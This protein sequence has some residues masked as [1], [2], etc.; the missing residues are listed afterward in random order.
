MEPNLLELSSWR[1]ALLLL[2]PLLY[3]GAA[4]A[5]TAFRARPDTGWRIARWSAA[6][7]MA[8]ALLSLIALLVSGA[9][10]V[11][12]PALLSLGSAGVVHFGLRSDALG[13]T[14]QMLVGFIG[15][16]IVGYS[17]TYLGGAGGQP[18]YIRCLLLT[19]SAV[20]LLVVSNNL[21]VLVLAW[22]ATSLALHGLLTFFAT[23]PQALVAAHKKFLASRVADLCLLSG[24]ALIGQ[25][26]GTLDIDRAMA[27]ASALPAMSAA[28]QLAAVLLAISALLKCAQLPVHGWLIQVMEAPTPVSALLHAGVV[29]LG[30]F[31]LIRLGLLVADVPAAQA[32]LVVVG[33]VT[34][35]V[36]ALVMTTRVSVKVALAWSTCA[37]MGFMLLQCG[38]GLHGLALLHLVAHSLYKAHAFLSAGGA[39]EQDRVRQLMPPVQM[40]SLG[41]WWLGAIAGLG[42]V[43]LAALAVGLD[44]VAEPGLWAMG[45]VLALAIAPLLIGSL[46][47]FSGVWTLAGPVAAFVLVAVYFGLHAIFGSW[48]GS[49]GSVA[50]PGLGLV[51]WVALCFVLL[52]GVQ[53]VVRAR[54]Q[55]ALARRLYPVLFA[56][57]YLDD[58]F[59][60]L[61]FR[62]WPVRVPAAP[63]GPADAVP[64]A[65]THVKA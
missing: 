60:R 51:V 17:Q 5:A 22:I 59:T 41:Q 44:P 7:A 13:V 1:A 50:Q 18:R 32:L 2:V 10:L 14:M 40:P 62:L 58:L 33:S 45:V 38:L 55:G 16:V 9:A 15:W 52:Y 11:R 49:P 25:Q 39:V 12:G 31:L 36:A 63:S 34:A 23:R 27:A 28:L 42:V 61:T 46:S 54:P 53:G 21:V 19:L 20:T 4:V 8:M 24:V 43:A 64:P 30:G 6:L 35:V 37:Q 48:L 56:G 65:P 29:N 3:L 57:L 47:Q 26:L